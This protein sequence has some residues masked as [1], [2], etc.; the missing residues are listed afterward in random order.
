MLKYKIINRKKLA[1]TFIIDMLGSV[2][3]SPRLLLGKGGAIRP[4]SVRTILVIR[5]AY[6]G[7]VVMTLPL[8]E[9]LKKR[10]PGAKITFLTASS[11][12]DVLINNPY[13]DEILT[14]DPIWFY[15]S[16]GKKQ[17]DFMKEFRKRSF[18]LV[19][20][21]R[22]D[23]REILYLA[24]PLK[25]RYRVGFGFGGGSFLLT[26]VVPYTGV[27]H[28]LEYHLDIA[29]YLGCERDGL[30]WGIYL[31]EDEKKR[32]QEILEREGIQG[33]FIAVHPGARHVLRQWFRERYAALYDRIATELGVPVAIVGSPAERDLADAVSSSMRTKPYNFA[34]RANLREL[35]GILSRATMFICNNSGPMHIAASMET[36]TVVLHGPSKTYWDAPYATRSR[37]VEKEFACRHSCDETSCHNERYHAC[38]K[39]IEVDDVF[40]AVLDLKREL[41]SRC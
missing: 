28:K 31:T 13:V 15:P 23:I 17:G 25:A 40:T 26:H 18:D 21:A 6:M 3:F 24:Y 39:D 20:E 2:L 1:A 30:E 5:T 10:F 37:I 9:P 11:A 38:M 41:D 34:G 33:P 16:A 35:A 32:V 22:G 19:I 29:D 12:K 4:E 27:K 7:D 36:P 14:Y 8:L